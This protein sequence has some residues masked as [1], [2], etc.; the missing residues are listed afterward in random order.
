MSYNP[1]KPYKNA[2]LKL[3][4]ETWHTP[5]I[6]VQK[7]AYSIFRRKFNHPEVDHTDGIGTKGIFHWRKRT[8]HSAVLDALAMNLNDLAMARAIPYKLQ[9]HLILSEDD[10]SAI[11][12]IMGHLVKEC[13][14]RQIAITGGETSI[15][16]NFEGFDIGLTVSGFVKKDKK[17]MFFTG[18]VLVGLASDG[19]HSNGFTT[20]RKVLGNSISDELTKPTK[21]YFDS[22]HELDNKYNINGMMHIT[23]GAFT[24]LKDLLSGTDAIITNTHSLKPQPIFRKIYSRKIGDRDMYK[25]F[26]CGIGFI[27]ST[28][29][30]NA[31]KIASRVKGAD[32]V[33][34]VIPG[35]GK[36]K[37]TS[38]FSG[39]ELSL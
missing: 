13:K 39:K 10:K 2:V 31:F 17:N 19:L 16:N 24:K 25:T 32:I 29:A 23:G 37:I 14:K 30:V 33:G 36:V 22:L 8:F 5:Y 28:S 15:Q 1:T 7:G 18:D 9:C 27:L 26:N 20:V 38:M 21:I 4:Q 34:K 12:E 11:L 6:S 3:I 35:M